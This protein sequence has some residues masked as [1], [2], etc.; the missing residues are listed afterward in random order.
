MVEYFD[1]LLNVEC[2]KFF[3]ES[4]E[5]RGVDA[6]AFGA[7]EIQTATKRLK[8]KKTAGICE[9]RNEYPISSVDQWAPV[10]CI[11]YLIQFGV[12]LLRHLNAVM[13]LFHLNI[14]LD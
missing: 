5:S 7:A 3:H 8:W 6:K 11:E 4:E 13:Q 2:D 14:Y 1:E 9:I 10:G 12:P